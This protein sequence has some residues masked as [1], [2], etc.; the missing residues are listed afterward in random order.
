MVAVWGEGLLPQFAQVNPKAALAASPLVA[1]EH[2]SD[3]ADTM[4]GNTVRL[5]RVAG[6]LRTKGLEYLLQAVAALRGR[7]RSVHLDLVGADSDP[8]Y[9]QQLL[10]L[11]RSLG[12]EGCVT[13]VGHVEFGPQLFDLYRAADVHVVSSISEGVPRCIVEGRA[14]GL[15]TVATRVG[16]IPSVVHDGADGLLVEAKSGEAIAAAV[17]RLMEDGDLRRRIIQQGYR[18]AEYETVEFQARR[19]ATL[20]TRALSGQ[21]LGRAATD[22]HTI[23]A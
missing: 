6:I 3:R 4:Q 14:F 20:I 5:I 10:G 13:W 21:P 19:L 18:L 16:G 23:E 12:I 11:C 1:R 2:I 8:V 15:P 9:R 17:E 7:G 22:L